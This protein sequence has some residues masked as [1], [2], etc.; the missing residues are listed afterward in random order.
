MPKRID[1]E[2]AVVD[3]HSAMALTR[4]ASV[5]GHAARSPASA[6]ESGARVAELPYRHKLAVDRRVQQT[7]GRGSPSLSSGLGLGR[8]L[9]HQDRRRAESVLHGTMSSR[10][11]LPT[12]ASRLLSSAPVSGRRT[13]RPLVSLPGGRPL[14]RPR[15][16]ART[17]PAG[18]Q[19]FSPLSTPRRCPRP[20][21]SR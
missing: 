2:L 20:W 15:L 8:P 17:C 6:G 16:G 19:L 9:T 13:D 3:D 5:T 21:E 7:C 18:A 11:S 14:E 10:S 12:R 4:R 1:E